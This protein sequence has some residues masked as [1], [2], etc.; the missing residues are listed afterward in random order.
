MTTFTVVAYIP[1][2]SDEADGIVHDTPKR[3]VDAALAADSHARMV[4]QNALAALRDH[5]VEVLVIA[6][7]LPSA[8]PL[9]TTRFLAMGAPRKDGFES[10]VPFDTVAGW[11]QACKTDRALFLEETVGR[12]LSRALAQQLAIKGLSDMARADLQKA[13]AC[14]RRMLRLTA[15]LRA[16]LRTHLVLLR[17]LRAAVASLNAHGSFEMTQAMRAHAFAPGQMAVLERAVTNVRAIQRA[18]GDTRRPLRP[19]ELAEM[20]ARN[21]AQVLETLESA[22]VHL[23]GRPF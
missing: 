18:A 5:T 19:D 8:D 23:T 6:G 1:D 15:L 14:A 12:Q 22:L 17:D 16:R 3:R 4:A 13:R 21:K 10:C 20:N 9:E 11:D 2:L 7:L